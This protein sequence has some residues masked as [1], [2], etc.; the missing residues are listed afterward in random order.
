M[1]RPGP[2]ADGDFNG[3]YIQYQIGAAVERRYV[4]AHA[5][6][7]LTLLTPADIPVGTIVSA[8]S[9]CDHTT[10]AGGCA[11]FDNITNFGGQENIPLKNPMG[12]N[13]IF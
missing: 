4:T 6:D 8:Y 7:T 13:P 1:P 12:S 10:G 3:G 2:R 5:G 9:G 11:K